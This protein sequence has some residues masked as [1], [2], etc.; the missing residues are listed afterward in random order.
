MKCETC[1]DFD[2]CYQCPELNV[3]RL[4]ITQ[5]LTVLGFFSY[6]EMSGLG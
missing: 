2:I 6:M 5:I 1:E 3:E 4:N